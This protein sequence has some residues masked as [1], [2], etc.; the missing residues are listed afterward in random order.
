MVARVRSWLSSAASNSLPHLRKP[1]PRP[2]S[3]FETLTSQVHC[4]PLQSG[5]ES[6]L[7][8]MF[9]SHILCVYVYVYGCV[10]VCIRVCVGVCVCACLFA[11]LS[12]YFTLHPCSAVGCSGIP[13]PHKSHCF[14]FHLCPS[15]PY[16]PRHVGRMLDFML[17]G[18]PRPWTVSAETVAVLRDV[19]SIST[20]SSTDAARLLAHL[21]DHL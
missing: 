9:F 8:S 12:S 4:H 5:V 13:C 10:C 21:H 11:C 3:T 16:F 7:N 18:T 1:S 19:T 2:R 17:R 20:L 6:Y 14:R 15:I